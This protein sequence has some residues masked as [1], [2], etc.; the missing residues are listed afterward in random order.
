MLVDLVK[1]VAPKN[2]TR[3][4]GHENYLSMVIVVLRFFLF[5]KYL[6]HSFCTGELALAYTTSSSTSSIPSQ[7]HTNTLKSYVRYVL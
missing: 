1:N 3:P 7:I 4:I 2:L 6:H 5:A